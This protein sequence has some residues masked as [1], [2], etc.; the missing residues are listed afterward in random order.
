ME[1]LGNP[2]L[3]CRVLWEIQTTAHHYHPMPLMAALILA[4]LP[5]LRRLEEFFFCASQI[6][7][8][9]GDYSGL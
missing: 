9:R 5:W 2:G 1:E 7:R 6:P 4:W 8:R 3:D